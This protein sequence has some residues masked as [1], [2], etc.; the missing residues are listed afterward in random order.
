MARVGSHFHERGQCSPG[1]A[2]YDDVHG[3]NTLPFLGAG[4]FY[5]EFGDFDISLTVPAGFQVAATGALANPTA[6]RTPQERARLA[7]GFPSP[8]QAGQVPTRQETGAR[9]ARPG[10]RRRAWGFP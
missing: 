3:W 1:L 9:R 5:L 10:P 4:E 8:G 2:V 6:I 7:G